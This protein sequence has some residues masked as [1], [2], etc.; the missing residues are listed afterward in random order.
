MKARILVVDD[1][2]TQ[3]EVIRQVLE[4]GGYSVMLAVDGPAA[5][6]A[7]ELELPD[8]LLS[9]VDM[10]GM[11]GYELCRAIRGRRLMHDLPVV[12]LTVL[13]HPLDIL[14]GLECGAD[15]Y[16]IKPVGEVLLDRVHHALQQRSVRGE[17]RLKVGLHVEVMGEHFEVSPDL[18]KTLDFLLTTIDEAMQ[19]RQREHDAQMLLAQAREEGLRQRFF[20]VAVDLLFLLDFEGGIRRVNPASENILGHVVTPGTLLD[21]VHPEDVEDTRQALAR[22]RGGEESVTFQN[23]LRTRQ[24]DYRMLSWNAVASVPDGVV[25]AAARD[26][27]VH[28]QQQEALRRGLERQAGMARFGQEALEA[29]DL[30]VLAARAVEI[31][32]EVLEFDRVSVWEFVEARG[33]LC[34]AAE[35]GLPLALPPLVAVSADGVRRMLARGPE[36]VASLSDAAWVEVREAL[37]RR[38]IQSGALLP[39]RGFGLLAA[40]SVRVDACTEQDL[41]FLRAIAHTLTTAIERQRLEMQVR[42]AQKMEAVGALAA[43]IA[44]DFNNLLTGIIGYGD[45]LAEHVGAQDAEA[46]DMLNEIRRAADW[47]K[48]LTRQLLSFS[49]RDM[50]EIKIL[51]VATVLREQQRM[52]RRIIGE[53]VVLETRAE[54]GPFPVRMDAGQLEQII[55]NLVVNAR[56]AMPQGGL[57]RLEVTHQSDP[58]G[59]QPGPYHRLVVSDTGQG[60]DAAT[61]ARIFEPFFTT[62]SAGHGTG[63]GLATVHAIVTQAGGAIEVFSEVGQGTQF[64]ILLPASTEAPAPPPVVAPASPATPAVVLVVEDDANVRRLAVRILE[65]DAYEVLPAGDADTARRLS[66]QRAGRI[67]L[68]LT[69]VVMPLV[70]GPQLVEMLLAERPE[71]R[72]LY[73][74]GYTED[75]VL[76]HG[77]ATASAAYL[78]KPY[79]P[80]ALLDKVRGLLADSR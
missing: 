33:G 80:R 27:T 9:D 17:R 6:A 39:I 41:V 49:R 78:A 14:R 56:D 34:L 1:S 31:V 3:R 42:H 72:V 15:N 43:G 22:L 51:D 71:M 5:L 12:L 45:L 60:M 54:N 13:E 48:S 65:M 7:L 70:S 10:P 61:R 64:H 36:L 53:D 75:A 58:P 37:A 79:S 18:E 74:S 16:V 28:H 47:A 77:L 38:G 69:D 62:K 21:H 76:R 68:L 20:T 11:N 52:L 67:D 26:V 23:R 57:V 50:V 35:T 32:R 63:L 2:S 73:T 29:P 55:L 19:I 4:E 66:Q 25:Y 24:G 8:L 44:H 40:C 59:R 30:K 46:L